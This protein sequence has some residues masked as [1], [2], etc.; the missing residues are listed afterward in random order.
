MFLSCNTPPRISRPHAG[1]SRL[2]A[3]RGSPTPCTT[4]IRKRKAEPRPS[5]NGSNT[6][7]ADFPQYI[8]RTG[9]LRF[10][11][12]FLFVA[13]IV[14]SVP[15]VRADRAA[16]AIG[17]APPAA[18]AETAPSAS[19]ETPVTQAA[20]SDR[21]SV[22]SELA[23]FVP[24]DA[25]LFLELR[26]G[27]ALLEPLTEAPLW[28]ALAE[29]AGQPANRRELDEWRARIQESVR[30][31]P[32]AAIQ[33]LFSDC[34]AYVG[35]GVGRSQDAVVLCRPARPIAELL[36]DWNATEQAAVGAA[37]TFRLPNQVGVA[38]RD[39]I[40]VFGDATL[41]GGMFARVVA[42]LGGVDQDTLSAAAE[43]GR[44]LGAAPAAQS[45]FIFVRLSAKQDAPPGDRVTAGAETRPAN[46]ED[47]AFP[48]I[49]PRPALPVATVTPGPALD[50]IGLESLLVALE[51]SRDEVTL[52]LYGSPA[53]AGESAGVPATLPQAG[54]ASLPEASHAGA[55]LARLPRTT[56]LAWEGGV[57]YAEWVDLIMAL[58]PQHVARIFYTLHEKAGNIGRLLPA[59][60][61]PT[62]V[63]V[64]F[65]RPETRTVAAP[66]I[67]AAALILTLN[68]PAAAAEWETLFHA[69]ASLFNLLALRAGFRVTLPPIEPLAL[70]GMRAEQLD[71]SGILG[72]VPGDTALGALHLSWAADDNVLML[73]THSDWLREIVESRRGDGAALTAALR[74]DMAVAGDSALT[75]PVEAA[76]ATRRVYLHAAAV[77]DLGARWLDYFERHR[78]ELLRET[79]WR[80]YQPSV[81]ATRLGIAVRWLAPEPRLRVESVLPHLPADGRLRPGDVLIGVERQRFA[82]SQPAQEMQQRVAARP[83]SRWIDLLI[84]RGGVEQ[85]QRIPLP[86]LDPIE[87]LRRA[88]ALGRL[89]ERGE[90]SATP[91][92]ALFRGRLMIKLRIRDEPMFDFNPGAGVQ[93]ISS[94]PATASQPSAPDIENA[95]A[96]ATAPAK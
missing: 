21:Q 93:V 76:F 16:P 70:P 42:C 79:W 57:N 75:R 69:S 53:V 43:F 67:P 24:A 34:V 96:S 88:I 36:R 4:D 45:G 77:A 91:A 63:A 37:R 51:K 3:L 72:A 95:R 65:V 20:S 28:L 50:G 59:L 64:G 55:L 13:L 19:I 81:A 84:E 41:A 86:F 35:A 44:L 73:A 25:G 47:S 22:R 60:D 90:F 85:T 27:A 23:R 46:G 48:P 61:A 52:S 74:G 38:T 82:T 39:K 29:L 31:A 5:G 10:L 14:F 87:L 12:A 49:K 26:D 9:P 18:A 94:N 92:A 71:L 11:H 32:R 6:W 1:Q 58:P 33:A 56:L 7:H 2:A 62:C 80:D 54:L 40:L 66:P 78:P 8:T 68:S 83:N 30:L 89:V 17:V 15:A